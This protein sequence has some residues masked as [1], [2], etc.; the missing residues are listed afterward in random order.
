M[1]NVNDRM[2]FPEDSIYLDADQGPL[3]KGTSPLQSMSDMDHISLHI[4]EGAE[5]ANIS[6]LNTK[7]Y[8]K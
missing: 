6:V 4:R 3:I 2:H 7:P 8:V 1:I 5:L